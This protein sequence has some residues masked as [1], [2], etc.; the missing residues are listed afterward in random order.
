MQYSVCVET[1]NI[2]KVEATS[3][4]DAIKKV[5]SALIA[6]KQMKETD[7]V[8]FSVAKEVVLE[9]TKNEKE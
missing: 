8:T 9:D 4:D 3:E 2:I 6:Q 7:P 5:R 1:L